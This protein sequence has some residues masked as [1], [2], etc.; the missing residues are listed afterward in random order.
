MPKYCSNGD[1]IVYFSMHLC[2]FLPCFLKKEG[3]DFQTFAELFAPHTMCPPFMCPPPTTMRWP[4]PRRPRNI[5]VSGQLGH[6]ALWTNQQLP[7]PMDPVLHYVS[8]INTLSHFG[9]RILRVRICQEAV[10]LWLWNLRRGVINY[11]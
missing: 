7:N 2:S 6:P 4:P 5:W 8:Q 10:P 9:F 11:P 3:K 1:I